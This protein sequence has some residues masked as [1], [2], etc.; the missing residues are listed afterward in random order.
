MKN[1]FVEFKVSNFGSVESYRVDLDNLTITHK[2]RINGSDI[3]DCVKITI[4]DSFVLVSRLVNELKF[5][6]W[7]SENEI[8]IMDGAFWS[9]TYLDGKVEKCYEGMSE[10]DSHFDMS[11]SLLSR[12][13]E[14]RCGKND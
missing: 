14:S 2:K 3:D 10:K 13:F 11:L 5:L 4:A 8:A 9:L 1:R 6:D 12:L 7:T